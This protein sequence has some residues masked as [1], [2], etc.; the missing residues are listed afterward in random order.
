MATRNWMVSAWLGLFIIASLV[1]ASMPVEVASAATP[2]YVKTT[3]DDANDGTTW[4]LAKR[5]IQDALDSVDADGTVYVMAGV[6]AEALTIDK[7]VA[8]GGVKLDESLAW[9]G[10]TPGSNG[11]PTISYNGATTHMINFRADDV[12]IS[13]FEIDTSGGA[14]RGIKFEPAGGTV[15]TATVQ[16]CSFTM[17][18]GDRGVTVDDNFTVT[19]LLVT[20]CAFQG[21]ND[22]NSNWFT[23]GAGTGALNDGGSVDRATLSYNT[24]SKSTSELRLDRP[25]LN[26]AYARN[27]FSQT[28][29]GILIIEPAEQAANKFEN[30]DIGYNTFNDGTLDEYAVLVAGVEQA[31]LQNASWAADLDMRYNNILTVGPVGLGLRTFAAVGFDT[32]NVKL[33]GL[34]PGR[35]TDIDATDN[36]WGNATGPVVQNPPADN[37][38]DVSIN[39]TFT[40]FL[41][42]PWTPTAASAASSGGGSGGCFIGAMSGDFA[43]GLMCAGTMLALVSLILRRTVR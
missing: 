17:D 8:I 24:I 18:A 22:G 21:P 20:Y 5:T 26:V 1:A 39:V 28:V 3:G 25:I 6:Y 9:T 29:G 19:D 16:Y 32:G 38:P 7:R 40:S 33:L 23:V 36:Y 2:I 13:G 35:T 15:A 4:A 43:P 11:G 41:I 34:D 14:T 42:S 37:G 27:T 30:I 31:D 12:I 10:G